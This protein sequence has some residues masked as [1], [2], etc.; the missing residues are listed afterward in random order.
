MLGIINGQLGNYQEAE[1][2]LRS[3]ARI[4]PNDPGCHFNHGNALAALQRYDEA[5][6]AFDHALTLNPR[7][8]RCSTQPRRHPDEAQML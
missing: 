3:A 2:L 5:L 7:I 6:A 1:R 8:R 4:N